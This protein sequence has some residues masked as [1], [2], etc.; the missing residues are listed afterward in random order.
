MIRVVKIYFMPVLVM[1]IFFLGEICSC[2][3]ILSGSLDGSKINHTWA[4]I[5]SVIAY[6]LLIKDL[7]NGLITKKIF[8]ILAILFLLLILYSSSSFFY[9]SNSKYTSYLLVYIAETIPAAYIGMRFARFN[10]LDRLNDL[11]PYFVFFTSV[12]I[13][14]IGLRY[15]AIGER[16]SHDDSG[17][18]YQSVSYYMAFEFS[19]A[20]YY[21][22]FREKKSFN[23]CNAILR[24]LMILMMFYCAII[25]LMSGGRGAFVY[26]VGL[27]FYLVVYYLKR[28]K[29]HL[30][31]ATLVVVAVAVTIAFLMKHFNVMESAGM[32]RVMDRITD[33]DERMG[34]YRKAFD[35][36]MDSP[37]FGKGVGSIWW[38]VGFYSH[39]MVLDIL[40]EM[41]LIGFFFFIPIL[42]RTLY[43][44][45]QNSYFEKTFVLLFIV[46]S[47]A[48][49]RNIFSSYWV[50]A[51]KLFFICSFV[52]CL[53]K[54]NQF[55]YKYI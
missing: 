52:Y 47:G 16:V 21:A 36:F 5:L 44:L 13:G 10:S 55:K 28:S 1:L 37:I 46:M 20:C 42:L 35:V 23:I 11:L 4:K 2:T 40:A 3:Q 18:N 29:R 6:S 54:L 53:P 49:I 38:T 14:T 33:D 26:I 34:L 43:R 12:L 7:F 51:T 50:S 15:A 19:Y 22:F 17:L 24:G 32:L 30:M 25:C 27:S 9:G 48:L 39:N 45:Y 8:K 31:W 41:G